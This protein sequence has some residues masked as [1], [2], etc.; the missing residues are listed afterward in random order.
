M[1]EIFTLE[2]LFGRFPGGI[3][4]PRIQRGYVQGRENSK[5]E[6][7]RA[8]FVPELVAAIF[9]GKSL[10]LDFLYGVTVEG[11][12]VE[13]R[14]LMP[15][16]G[17]QRLTTLAILAWLCGK[18]RKE[19]RFAYESRRIPELFMEGLLNSTPPKTGKASEMARKAGWF[20]PVWENDPTV[21]GMLRMLDAL[22]AEIGG[23]DR[24]GADFG[25]IT[26]L[27]HGIDG[28][29]ETFDHIFRKMN[30][31]GKE[32]SPW[33]NLKAMLDKHIPQ[34]LA[35]E[36]RE[37]VDGDWPEEIWSHV[38][39]NVV[40]LDNAMEKVLRMAYARF[41]SFGAQSATLWQMESKLAS[42]GEEVFDEGTRRAFYQTATAYFDEL[43]AVAR[44]WTEER[45]QNALWGETGNENAFWEW[46]SNGQTASPEDLLRVAFLAEKPH[47]GDDK[48]RRRILLNLLDASSITK[49]NV[50]KAQEAGLGFHAG[51][52]DLET[53]KA[54]KV[55]YSPEQLED[56]IGKRA[57]DENSIV[58]F[59]K[60]DL[61]FHGSFRFISWA[62]FRDAEDI[63]G[64]LA[65]IRGAI[66]G[67]KWLNF[68]Q[69]LVSRIA[70]EKFGGRYAYAPLRENDT[71]VWRECILADGRFIDALKAWHDVP[72]THP[73]VPMWLRHLADL[74]RD[75]Q[76]R[77]S[78]L[79]C[80]NGW[81]FLLQHDARR[82]DDSLRLDWNEKERKN[83]QLLKTG[84]VYY[85]ASWPWAKAKERDVWYKV[86]DP[87]W[88]ESDAPPKWTKDFDGEFCLQS[89][90]PGSSK[91][92]A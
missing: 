36:W 35:D 89:D 13:E 6:A 27:L 70:E 43:Q 12:H 46:L 49:E 28:T 57:I 32:L 7:I 34:T 65:A 60:D 63:R 86:D 66:A 55:G 79:R 62:P 58:A 61:V 74:L 47:C 50:E 54:K 25:T 20:L 1:S 9:G 82:R 16:D 40:A 8:E 22:D 64:R 48:R 29:V 17:Q 4:V 33:E 21:A 77:N 23:R 18:W 81:M 24:T 71:T 59:E 37:K 26:F 76:V 5:G 38:G 51:A 85:T 75:G 30:A 56:E 91:V 41:T 10:S 45:T 80:W 83:R 72:D 69:N 44:C 2:K 19:W 67:D 11:K 39:G 14:C 90:A 15:L 78:A 92:E 53:L 3:R 68:Y 73:E 42:V 31:R 84:Q 52:L 87:S 88:W